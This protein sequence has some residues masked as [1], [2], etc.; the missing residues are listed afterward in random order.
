MVHYQEKV[1]WLALESQYDLLAGRYI[2]IGL[3]NEI[4]GYQYDFH[5]KGISATDYTPAALRR[6]GR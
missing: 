6:A 4:K 1:P 2:T 3:D 5:V